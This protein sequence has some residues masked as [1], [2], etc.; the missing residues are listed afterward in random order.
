M[1]S[2]ILLVLTATSSSALADPS[3]SFSGDARFGVTYQ[4]GKVD[5]ADPYGLL[6]IDSRISTVTDSGI[7]LGVQLRM[8]K[9]MAG[10]DPDVAPRF[11]ISTG[12]TAPLNGTDSLPRIP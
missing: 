6:R 9:R 12:D 4:G 10:A 7:T 3:L 8:T 1:R 11:T 5:Q 2:L